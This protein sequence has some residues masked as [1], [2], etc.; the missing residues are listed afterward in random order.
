MKVQGVP[1]WLLGI[2]F[3]LCSGHPRGL[4][5]CPISMDM[6]HLQESFQDIQRAIQANDTFQNITILS[7]LDSLQGIKM[8]DV[9]CVTRSLLA[10]Y[11]DKVF[12]DH[13]EPD[14]HILRRISSIANSF[15]YMQKTVQQCQV[16]RQCPCR[17]EAT[18]VTKIIHNNYN[19]LEARVAAIKSLGELN[20]FLAWISENHQD[21]SAA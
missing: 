4:R 9:C 15:L 1:L 3:V 10:F 6:R 13:Q 16:Q 12:K 20:V 11:M 19:Q 21:G 17:E 7:A 5:R 8:L 18:N 14:P 2:A